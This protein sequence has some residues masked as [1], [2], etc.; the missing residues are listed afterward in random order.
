MMLPA[1]DDIFLHIGHH[2]NKTDFG[3]R[4]RFYLYRT[5]RKLHYLR[6]AAF[7]ETIV[8]Q[9]RRFLLEYKQA[10]RG[11]QQHNARSRQP[12]YRL[13]QKENTKACRQQGF[14]QRQR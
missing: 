1:S 7:V 4:S 5:S 2:K 14:G 3:L 13:I 6:S 8:R 9:L 10:N 12:C 11:D